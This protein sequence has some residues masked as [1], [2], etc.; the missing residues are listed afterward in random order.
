MVR[1]LGLD[2]VD[3]L[4]GRA[5][6]L[7]PG[8]LFDCIVGRAFSRMET[9]LKISTPLLAE[10]GLVIAM[11]GKKSEQELRQAEKEL[12]RAQLSIV[13]ERHFML[14]FHGGTRTIVVF[15]KNVSRE[16]LT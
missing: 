9:F 15:K 1:V 5:E 16:T 4:Q 7:D 14:P 2:A 11:K 10:N 13:E 6:A 3:V 8:V 12:S